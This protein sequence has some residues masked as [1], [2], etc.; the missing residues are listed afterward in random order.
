MTKKEPVVA[1]SFSEPSWRWE[2]KMP[3]ILH[4]ALIS[5]ICEREQ[6]IFSK[7]LKSENWIV[8]KVHEFL[9]DLQ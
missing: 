8:K 3:P 4:E 6:H 5:K 2:Q 7:I 9:E 1:I